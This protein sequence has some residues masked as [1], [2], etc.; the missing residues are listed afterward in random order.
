MPG[1]KEG[2]FSSSDSWANSIAGLRT[3]VS[4]LEASSSLTENC[5]QNWRKAN[6]RI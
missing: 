6:P 4:G 5:A 3:F 2:R 1:T